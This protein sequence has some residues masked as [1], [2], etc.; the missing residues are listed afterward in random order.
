MGGSEGCSAEY[1]LPK[2]ASV[3][4]EEQPGSAGRVSIWPLI[5]FSGEDCLHQAR[6]RKLDKPLSV[7]P[8]GLAPPRSPDDF[9][10]FTTAHPTGKTRYLSGKDWHWLKC[11]QVPLSFIRRRRRTR[12]SKNRKTSLS[13]G[14]T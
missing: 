3:N 8:L 4:A 6:V 2:A 5:S 14:R 7:K 11:V 10:A 13:S 12:R 9:G 1:G